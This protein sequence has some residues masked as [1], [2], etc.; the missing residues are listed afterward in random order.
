MLEMIVPGIC[1]QNWFEHCIFLSY[2]LHNY[3]YIYKIVIMCT[4]TQLGK[5]QVKYITV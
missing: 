1:L 3:L 5:Y 2:S 4:F